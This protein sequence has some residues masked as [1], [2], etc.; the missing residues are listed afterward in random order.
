MTEPQITRSLEVY[1]LW[2]LGKI[3]FIETHGDTS[4]ARFIPIALEIVNTVTPED[5]IP[6]S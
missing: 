3:M 5:I 2:L 6:R 4:S 1:I